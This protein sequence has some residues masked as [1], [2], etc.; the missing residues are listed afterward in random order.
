MPTVTKFDVRSLLNEILGGEDRWLTVEQLRMN[1]NRISGMIAG[2]RQNY[3]SRTGNDPAR[4]YYRACWKQLD[5]ATTDEE[6]VEAIDFLQ[7]SIRWE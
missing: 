4:D 7:S 5:H 6:V 1:R 2:M 3:E